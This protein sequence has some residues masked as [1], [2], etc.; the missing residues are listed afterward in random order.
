MVIKRNM[1]VAESSSSPAVWVSVNTSLIF[2]LSFQA[3]FR[4]DCSRRCVCVCVF[5]MLALVCS[6]CVCS[7][8]SSV[9]QKGP[10]GFLH[11]LLVSNRAQHALRVPGEDTYSGEMA[12][13]HEHS[14]ETNSEVLF[15]VNTYV[16]RY[17]RDAD[18]LLC[19]SGAN[20]VVKLFA[21]LLLLSRLAAANRLGPAQLCIA[22]RSALIQGPN[23]AQF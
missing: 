1:R 7:V 17:H 9:L 14:P 16:C 4:W 3:F 20:K 13:A 18:L 15:V 8:C 5:S 11:R 19:S 23:T 6:V 2:S 10:G 21:K 12:H 22:A